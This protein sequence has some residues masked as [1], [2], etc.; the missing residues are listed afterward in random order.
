[1]GS[2]TAV[3][4]PAGGPAPAMARTTP[5]NSL[6]PGTLYGVGLGPGDPELITVKAVRV[7]ERVEVIFVPR[8]AGGRSVARRIADSYLDPARQEIVELD[9][10][11]GGPRPATEAQWTANAA[12]IA[13]YLETG[14]DGAFLTEGDPLF[15]STFIHVWRELRRTHPAVP[16]RVVP[17]VSSIFAAAGA[18]LESLA[19]GSERVAILPALTAPADLREV[20]ERFET[21][22]LL[23]VGGAIDRVVA[24]LTELDLLQNTVFV[25]RA[26]W[27]DEVVIRNLGQVAGRRPDYFSLLIV[28]KRILSNE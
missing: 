23:K 8:R 25:E 14:Q 6:A 19:V 20:L 7:L 24:V 11:M 18:A 22:V 10:Q 3:G 28:R 4:I 15:Y 9:H 5:G 13:G 21:V 12:T 1:M 16:V 26:G 27:P 17:G 2:E